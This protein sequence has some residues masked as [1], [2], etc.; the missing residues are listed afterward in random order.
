VLLGY[1][2]DWFRILPLLWSWLEPVTAPQKRN[3]RGFAATGD[4]TGANSSLTTGFDLRIE[5]GWQAL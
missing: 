1:P 5:I 4:W 3:V 2:I